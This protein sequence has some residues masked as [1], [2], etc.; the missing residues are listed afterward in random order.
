MTSQTDLVLAMLRRRGEAGVTPLDALDGVG[1][2]RL[3]ARIFE[4]R[5]QGHVIRNLWQT[6]TEGAR[7]ARYVLDE[8]AVTPAGHDPRTESWVCTTCSAAAG[9]RPGQASI[10]P[11]YRTGRCS[12][13]GNDTAFARRI[14]S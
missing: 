14:A 4:L 1:S 13:C 7:I 2:F 9:D 5:R 12:A 10:D 11:R 8:E 3:G 6:T